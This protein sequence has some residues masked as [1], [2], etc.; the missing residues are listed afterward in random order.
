MVLAIAQEQNYS[1]MKLWILEM[2][3][4]ASFSRQKKKKNKNKTKQKETE[5]EMLASVNL[6]SLVSVTAI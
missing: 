3:G 2:L 4:Y 5:K 6:D 1:V